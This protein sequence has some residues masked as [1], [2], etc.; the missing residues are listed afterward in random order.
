[1]VLDVFTCLQ[2]QTHLIKCTNLNLSLNGYSPL[3]PQVLD[4]HCWHSLL[5][6]LLSPWAPLSPAPDTNT[7]QPWPWHPVASLHPEW[8]LL[9]SKVPSV[10]SQN[11]KNCHHSSTCYP[12]LLIWE[13]WWWFNSHDDKNINDHSEFF[14]DLSFISFLIWSVLNK[15]CAKR[16]ERKKHKMFSHFH[17]SLYEPLPSHSAIYLT[18][19]GLRVTTVQHFQSDNLGEILNIS[20]F[21]EIYERADHSQSEQHK[22][23]I[24]I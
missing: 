7:W 4:A 12:T 15:K 11:G 8:G 1:M 10:S 21:G 19:A 24:E 9:V 3:K 14:V 20:L 18:P 5:S 2:N 13:R 23:V 16:I 6:W 17:S 22:S